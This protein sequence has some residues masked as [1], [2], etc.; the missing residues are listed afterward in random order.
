MLTTIPCSSSLDMKKLLEAKSIKLIDIAKRIVPELR[1]RN[2][3]V[4]GNVCCGLLTA[5]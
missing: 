4:R 3:D 1:K 5:Q 2:M